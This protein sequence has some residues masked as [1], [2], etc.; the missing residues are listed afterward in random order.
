[1]AHDVV[2]VPGNDCY[3]RRWV[4]RP[5]QVTTINRTHG[6]TRY[7]SPLRIHGAGDC[8]DHFDTI[9]LIEECALRNRCFLA[10]LWSHGNG[11]MVISKER[12]P[13]IL[14]WR[15]WPRGALPMSSSYDR[16]QGIQQDQVD[17][18]LGAFWEWMRIQEPRWRDQTGRNEFHI[19]P[20]I[21]AGQ[22]LVDLA[23]LGTIP[24]NRSVGRR[25]LGL[26]GYGIII[27]VTA[28]MAVVWKSGDDDAR[29]MIRNWIG[30]LN[31]VT[32][33]VGTKPPA[34]TDVEPVFEPSDPTQQSAAPLR[35]ASFDQTAAISHSPEISPAIQHQLEAMA[36]DIAAVQRI[37]MKLAV[38][39]DQIARDVAALI[40][41]EKNVSREL[42]ALPQ[43][44]TG[45]SALAPSVPQPVRSRAA[46]HSVPAH[47]QAGP[48]GP[49]LPLQ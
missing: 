31:G 2:F 49:A 38:Q 6:L 18:V 39:Q 26:F 22:P 34:V 42:S 37:E 21:A 28:G 44:T 11:L 20:G 29:T 41:S 17:D 19:S 30:S 12:P 32:S 48:I 13:A 3:I 43:L 5:L 33:I 46:V 9:A 16:N 27:T 23:A 1:M 47:T 14:L 4:T 35:P 36:S 40:L 7:N 24:R 45:H 15:N 10:M 8:P 25:V